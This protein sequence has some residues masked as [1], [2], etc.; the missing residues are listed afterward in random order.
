MPVWSDLRQ[1]Y[2]TLFH[3]IS[4]E[5]LVSDLVFCYPFQWSIYLQTSFEIS[6]DTIIAAYMIWMLRKKQ[7]ECRLPACVQSQTSVFNS[8]L[9]RFVL[10]RTLNILD[11]L[12]AYS[13]YTGLLT[14][15]V[16]P[17][18]FHVDPSHMICRVFYVASAITV[19]ILLQRLELCSL[20]LVV[21]SYA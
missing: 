14:V 5:R 15:Y 6:A 9:S 4:Y 18:S 21:R 10:C 12:M 7:N 2:V 16:H 19:S 13:L 8:D 17:P 11:T 20:M 3:Y 1:D